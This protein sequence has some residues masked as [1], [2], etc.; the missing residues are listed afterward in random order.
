MSLYLFV[1]A[2]RLRAYQHL[3][4]QSNAAIC[5]ASV[6]SGCF[7]TIDE[8]TTL[9]CSTDHTPDINGTLWPILILLILS[10]SCSSWGALA[11]KKKLGKL[12][13]SF[14]HGCHSGSL[15]AR[16]KSATA[17]R[18]FVKRYVGRF[19][20]NLSMKYRFGYSLAKVTPTSHEDVRTCKKTFR[21]L[22]RSVREV[23]YIT[24]ISYC[25]RKLQ[26]SQKQSTVIT[27]YLHPH[28]WLCGPG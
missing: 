7:K 27:L 18:G 19:Y 28:T 13:I 22:R 25:N 8:E 26:V 20:W 24:C 4:F 15:S 6:V 2:S 3:H 12:A 16:N 17:K 14:R 23:Q 1:Y 11:K 9:L 5:H 10:A 21:S